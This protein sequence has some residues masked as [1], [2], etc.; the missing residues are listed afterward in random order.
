MFGAKIGAFMTAM[1]TDLS[2]A[3]LGFVG[4]GVI[5]VILM[6][7]AGSF[8]GEHTITRAKSAAM[9]LLWGGAALAVAPQ[10]ATALATTT[11]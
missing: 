5:V 7:I 3:G 8:L 10:I 4:L 1:A 11:F 9:I 2:L 6:W